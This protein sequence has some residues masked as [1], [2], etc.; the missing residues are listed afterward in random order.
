MPVPE[1]QNNGWIGIPWAEF[2]GKDGSHG[3]TW[4]STYE[5]ESQ[6]TF[7]ILV[8]WSDGPEAETYLLGTSRFDDNTG[9]LYRTMPARHPYKPSQFAD[10]IV[11][12]QPLKWDSKAQ[13][14]SSGFIGQSAGAPLSQY[15]YW[16][17]TIGFVTPKYRVLSDADLQGIYGANQ[18]WRRFVEPNVETHSTTLVQEG[19][20]WQWADTAAG[21]PTLNQVL[22]AGFGQTFHSQT[23]VLRWRRLPRRGIYTESGEGL[24]LNRNIV[25][26]LNRVHNGA[27]DLWG[28]PGNVYS[29]VLRFDGAKATPIASPFAP[30][31]QGLTDTSINAYVDLEL[32]FTV[33]DPPFGD[34]TFVNPNNLPNGMRGHNLAPNPGDQKWYLITTGG[35]VGGTPSGA[36]IF[37]TTDLSAVFQLVVPG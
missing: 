23:I 22:K 36:L 15:Q 32:T 16:L 37:S 7:Q 24:F 25:S 1:L 29:G 19:Q 35:N 10:K 8:N 18:E 3:A 31:A 9:Y 5:G 20:T 14:F 27:T 30:E 11:S 21:G 13:N 12:A 33:W 4:N 34:T 17:L 26:C 2:I 28:L 6:S